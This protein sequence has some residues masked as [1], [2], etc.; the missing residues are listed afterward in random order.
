M[1][2][3]NVGAFPAGGVRQCIPFTGIMLFS[4]HIALCTNAM[5]ALGIGLIGFFGWE[6]LILHAK[7]Y[8]LQSLYIMSTLK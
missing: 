8:G 5:L 6:K 1:L 3:I 2:M 7:V 4:Q